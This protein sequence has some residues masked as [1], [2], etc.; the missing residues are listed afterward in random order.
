MKRQEFRELIFPLT[1]KEKYN[2]THPQNENHYNTINNEYAYYESSSNERDALFSQNHA[3]FY[4]GQHITQEMRN[5][6][7][8]CLKQTRYSFVPVHIRNYI[9][10]KY[11]YSGSV[12]AI[13]NDKTINL[14]AG[15]FLMI[16]QGSKHTILMPKDKDLIFNFQMDRNYFTHS[17]ISR[18]ED[19]EPITN[20]LSRVIDVNAKH[21]NY[22]LF[23]NREEDHSYINEIVEILLCEYLD[24]SPFAKT[25]IE[26]YFLL[27]FVALSKRY[28][29]NMEEIYHSKNKSY[30][31]EIIFYTKEHCDNCTL[32]QLS[33]KFSFNP[34]YISRSIKKYT[35]LSFKQLTMYYRLNKV[36]ND[37]IHTEEPIITIAQRHGF[38][39]M[40]FFYD[41]FKDQYQCPPTEFREKNK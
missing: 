22:V 34:D 1:Q 7:I 41:K 5:F 10:I 23:R 29:A 15:D 11:V 4:D 36:A 8:T 28:Q 37:L 32:N 26:S 40:N 17:F 3:I 20:F 39:N 25:V 14:N 31:S 35:G 38:S 30:I 18:F 9:E 2:K 6:P 33:E 21:D 16:D 12:N 13:I 27:L 24:P 19:S